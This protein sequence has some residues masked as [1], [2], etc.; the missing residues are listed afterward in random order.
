M[1]KRKI[2]ISIVVI[3]TLVLLTLGGCVPDAAGTKA[4]GGGWISSASGAPGEKATFGFTAQ[5][6]GMETIE[7]NVYVSKGRILIVD[8][9]TGQ[10]FRATVYGTYVHGDASDTSMFAG[11]TKDGSIVGIMVVDKDSNGVVNNGDEI[12]IEVQDASSV[13]VYSNT[14]TLKGGNIRV[15]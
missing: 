11:K 14:G 12:T 2:I 4:V 5:L 1:S 7:E 3:L 10:K 15:K 13:S 6:K 8:H 9:G